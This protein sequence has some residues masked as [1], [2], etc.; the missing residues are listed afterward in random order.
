MTTSANMY[1]PAVTTYD[2]REG[3]LIAYAAARRAAALCLRDGCFAPAPGWFASPF[4][5]VVDGLSIR[6]LKRSASPYAED[7]EALSHVL[8]FDGVPSINMGY[9]F[10]CTTGAALGQEGIPF[11]RR[12]L[13][14]P[15]AG[16]G[17]AVEVVHMKGPAGDYLNVTWP[18]AAGVLTASAPGR[19]CAAINQAPLHRVTSG[20]LLRLA[21]MARNLSRT[22]HDETGW[23]PDHLLRYAFE[24]CR[25]FEDAVKLLCREP[26]ARPVIFSICGEGPSDMAL[27]ERDGRN[28]RLFRGSFATANDWQ[29][30]HPRWEPRGAAKDKRRDNHERCA[31]MHRAQ[32]ADARD[33]LWLAPPILNARTRL[34]VE[35]NASGALKVQGFERGKKELIAK[36]ATQVCDTGLMLA[37]RRVI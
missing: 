28:A 13:D 12:V 1:L 16:L 15:L 17:R 11:M 34:A 32:V 30:A 31:L 22:L 14:W 6:W 21:D 37:S 36:P 4:L 25:T 8:G 7:V 23:P 9:Q 2:A 5:R 20:S 29:H 19:F 24:T 27:I 18:G 3:G 33:F 35:M 10:G 26:V